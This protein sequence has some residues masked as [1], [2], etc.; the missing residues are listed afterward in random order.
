MIIFFES[1]NYILEI[2]YILSMTLVII[3][4][5]LIKVVIS[6][7][8]LKKNYLLWIMLENLMVIYHGNLYG[9]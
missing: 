8:I 2:L 9:I 4:P 7:L 1:I 3:F 6:T 5:K